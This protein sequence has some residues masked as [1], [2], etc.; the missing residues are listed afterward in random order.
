MRIDGSEVDVEVRRVRAA[1]PLGVR[2]MRALTIHH[3][4]LLETAIKRN[5][6]G[7][8]GPRVITGDYR[9]SIHRDVRLTP[10]GA[11]VDV[12]TNAPQG[13]RLEYGFH[14]TDSLG[15]SFD[16]PPRPHFRPAADSIEAAFVAAVEQAVAA[17]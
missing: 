13:A 6:S 15:R 1:G 12:G 8:P 7:R 17:L 3:G 11:E 16:Q 10:G 9:R 5:A 4:A 14:G 2:K